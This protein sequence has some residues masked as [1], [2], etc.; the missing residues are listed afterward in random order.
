MC[1]DLKDNRLNIGTTGTSTP[2]LPESE[3]PECARLTSVDEDQIKRQSEQAAR[4]SEDQALAAALAASAKEAGA[5]SN[6]GKI[7]YLFTHKQWHHHILCDGIKP[8]PVV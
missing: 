4:L 7:T 1:I 8:K 5:S 2:F 6:S 3:L